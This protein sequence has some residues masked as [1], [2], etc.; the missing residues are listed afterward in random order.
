MKLISL[1]F[2][3]H[4]RAKKR[5]FGRFRAGKRPRSRGK[6][7]YSGN[8]ENTGLQRVTAP[9]GSV[10]MLWDLQGVQ[11]ATDWQPSRGVGALWG[12]VAVF[13]GMSADFVETR[14]YPAGWVADKTAGRERAEG[15]RPNEDLGAQGGAPPSLQKN[16]P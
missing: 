16:P 11:P 2:H 8:C 1:R 3:M 6:K 12:N 9:R 10:S 5:D 13:L 7:E 15:E 4:F 14:I